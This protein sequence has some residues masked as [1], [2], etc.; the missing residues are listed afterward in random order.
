MT[1]PAFTFTEATKKEAKARIALEGISGSGKTWT[2]L[3]IASA[4]GKRIGVIDTEHRSA[5]KYA[6]IFSFHHLPLDSY[7]PRILI[8]ALA[9]AG[10]QGIDVA[11]VDSMSHFW[12][13]TGGML[14][15]V[16][17]AAKRAGGHGMSGWKEMRPVERQMIEAILAFPGHVIVTLRVKNDW[18]EQE[19]RGRR[20]MV[21]VGTKAEQREGLEYEFDIVGS[22]SIDNE[23]VVSKS[24]CPQLA[25]A[26]IAKPSLDLGH[27]IREW[28]EDGEA[29]APTV[30]DFRARAIADGVTRTDL[31]ALHTEVRTAGLLAAPV[32]DLA[33]AAVSLGELIVQLGRQATPPAAA[34]PAT[35]A[36]VSEPETAAPPAAEAKPEPTAIGVRDWAL[37]SQ[38]RPD[39]IRSALARLRA[40]HPAIAAEVVTNEVGEPEPLADLLERRAREGTPGGAAE[41]VRLEQRSRR[42]FALFRELGYDG[43]TQR[44][45][46]LKIYTKILGRE[47]G[48]TKELSLADI[49]QVITALE[50]KKRELAAKQAAAQREAVPA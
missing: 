29:G 27:T 23:L 20:Q 5:L 15:A 9:A 26:V 2:A 25:G 14:E 50:E 33:G 35:A 28:L 18:V 46:R 37:K 40:E 47:V 45:N 24:R 43:D 30:A 21:K 4:L 11:V 39:E 41:G 7:D 12:M 6:G 32:L 1:M 8:G 19:V 48:S 38:R 13:G 10:D 17:N 42:M 31:L 49:E 44:E 22:L 36:P 16:D 3:T 34:E